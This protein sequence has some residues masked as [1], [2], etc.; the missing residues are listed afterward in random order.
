[1]T[2][3]TYIL[4]RETDNTYIDKSVTDQGNKENGSKAQNK[5]SG[6]EMEIIFTRDAQ[7]LPSGKDSWI[8]TWMC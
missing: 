5:V 7:G 3:W 4:I 1:M 8:E 6:W 2:L